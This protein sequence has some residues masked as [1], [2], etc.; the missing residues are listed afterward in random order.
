MNNKN[1]IYQERRQNGRFASFKAKCGR[2]F[3]FATRAALIGAAAVA[4]FAAGALTF[5][6][7]TVIAA[8]SEDV[9]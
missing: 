1:K 9:V 5:S 4:I 6:S 3:R 7:N 8:R 2:A